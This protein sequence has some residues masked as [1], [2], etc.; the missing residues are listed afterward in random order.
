[1]LNYLGAALA[2]TGILIL[3][4]LMIS[5][6]NAIHLEENARERRLRSL[7]TLN[8]LGLGIGVIGLMIIVVNSL[9]LTH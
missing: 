4:Y 5:A 2:I 7:V 6:K 8:F 9:I 3:I 1:M